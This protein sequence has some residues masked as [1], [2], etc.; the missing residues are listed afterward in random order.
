MTATKIPT[1]HSDCGY[2]KTAKQSMNWGKPSNLV[3]LSSSRFF[4]VGK[5]LTTNHSLNQ[6]FFVM[7]RSSHTGNK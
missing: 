5:I 7:N 4:N 6:Y 3:L 1:N 2:F